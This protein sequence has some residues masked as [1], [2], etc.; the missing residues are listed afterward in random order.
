MIE[1]SRLKKPQ[2]NRADM[3]K[4]LKKKKRCSKEDID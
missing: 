3:V 1:V 4:N 2:R